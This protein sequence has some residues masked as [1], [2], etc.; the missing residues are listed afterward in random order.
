MIVCAGILL[1][2]VMLRLMPPQLLLGK[3]PSGEILES[4]IPET[5]AGGASPEFDV[6]ALTERPL[7]DASR[8]PPVT[9]RPP[10][11]PVVNE[12]EVL[13]VTPV[14]IGTMKTAQGDMVAYMQFNGTGDT[15]RVR[16]GDYQDPWVVEEIDDGVVSLS[17]DGEKI[18]IQLAEQ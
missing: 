1:I 18:D 6:F 15:V 13:V 12:T 11:A 16:V 8:K 17:R 14:L 10:V 5:N 7:F 3:P 9:N 4:G 2:A